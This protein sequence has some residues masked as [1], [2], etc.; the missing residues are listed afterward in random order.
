ML[1]CIN[2]YTSSVPFPTKT[3]VPHNMP[4]SSSFANVLNTTTGTA[5]DNATTPYQTAQFSLWKTNYFSKGI[6]EE[7][8]TEVEDNATQFQQLLDKATSQGAYDDPQSFVASLSTTELAT[9]QHIHGLADPITPSSLSKEGALNLL[10]SPNQSQDIDKDGFEMIGLGKKY[11]FPP[12]NAP[13]N[14]KQAW[15]STTRNMSE[16]DILQLEIS[17]MPMH[18]P[19]NNSKLDNDA[20]IPAD[21]DYPALIS[22][23]LEG[24]KNN[25]KYDMP[26]QQDAR[27]AQIAGL[28]KFLYNLNA[29]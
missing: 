16:S 18:I 2:A 11:Q 3:N 24:A 10:L 5:S 25:R 8:R 14:V 9:L 1:S 13:E 28:E 20:Y 29:T 7:R 23:L 27:N 22:Q 21:A 17:V 4:A 12:P 26:W 15:S 6:S 19:A